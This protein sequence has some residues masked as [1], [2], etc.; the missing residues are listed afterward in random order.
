MLFLSGLSFP[1]DTNNCLRPPMPPKNLSI[2]PNIRDIRGETLELTNLVVFI[3]FA[4]DEEFTTDISYIDQ[5]FND[6]TPYAVSVYNY[7]DVMTYGKIKYR[8][9]YPNNVQNSTIVSYQ[10]YHPRGYYEP[11]SPTNPI[12]YSTEPDFYPYSREMQLIDR[13][14]RYIDSLNL[15]DENIS[16][17]GNNDGYIDNI[18]IVLKGNVGDWGDMLWP[19]M[20]FFSQ[21]YAEIPY[22]TTINGK[23]PLAYN[24]EFADSGP[25]FTANVFSHEMGHSLGI[26]DFYHYYNYESISP[27]GIWDQMAQSNLQQV[28]TILKYKFLG[29]VDEPIEITEDGHYVLNSNTSSDKENCYFIRSSIDPDQ[30]FTFE[31]RN[32][33]DFMDNIPQ[34]GLIIGRWFDNVDVNNL[35][36]SGN[37]LFDFHNKPHSYWIF[38]PNSNIDTINGN[39]YSAAFSHESGRTSFGPNT[40]PRPFLADGTPENSFE[41]TNIYEFGNTLSFDVRFLETNIQELKESE[42]KISPNPAKDILSIYCEEIKQI[43]VFD[44]LGKTV[45][46]NY[47][48][49][50]QI[51]ISSLNSG[52]YIIRVHTENGTFTNKFI[53][54]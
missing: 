34:S 39:I 1:F 20:E 18:S 10:D 14:L 37:G 25:Y 28:S 32:C 13:A 7:F 24:F 38:R 2:I 29:I 12:G 22:T 31:Y 36:D 40:N 50:N 27:V 6:S 19:H 35:Y 45:T 44:I 15:I 21:E 4:D 16:L 43:E 30:W 49:D 11:Q 42:L 26:P 23:S 9:I 47:S 33:N 53:K 54:E 41:I 5:M 8:S 48:Y 52:I 3:R 17:D 51:D 46:F